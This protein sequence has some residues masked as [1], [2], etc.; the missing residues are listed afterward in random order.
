[1]HHT[2]EVENRGQRPHALSASA[3]TPALRC[4]LTSSTPPR[5]MSSG[6][7]PPKAPSIDCL[8]HGLVNGTCYYLAANTDRIPL[9]DRLFDND[10][11]CMANLTAKT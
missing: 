4:P 9:T 1:M 6:L 10:S 3:I 5:T 2:L 8:P 11:F 7:I